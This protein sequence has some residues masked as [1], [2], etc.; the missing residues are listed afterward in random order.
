MVFGFANSFIDLGGE[1][2]LFKRYLKH[3]PFNPVRLS[4]LL[5]SSVYKLVFTYIFLFCVLINLLRSRR[6]KLLAALL[7]VDVLP[8]I[9]FALFVFEA[10]DM[11]RYVAALPLIFLA[12]GYAICSD[13]S[14]R[15]TKFVIVG[16]ILVSAVTNVRAMALPTLAQR[17]Q[18]VERRISPLLPLLKPGSRVVTSHLLDEVNNFTRDFLFNPI[19]RSGTLRYYA[20]VTLNTSQ[21]DHWQ[22]DFAKT[23][24]DVWNDNG[25]VWVSKRL[26]SQTPKAEWNWVEGDDSRVSWKDL[27]NFFLQF[28]F[29]KETIEEDGFLLLSRSQ[30]NQWIV[31][32]LAQNSKQ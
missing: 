16:F 1:G 19:N 21:V 12:I 22:Q 14:L 31:N 13:E 17:E 20:V 26:L 24:L 10:G 3:D 28:D 7:L 18:R 25:D 4:D 27:N 8:T 11:S 9:I 30:R 32:Q 29:E 5:W 2:G 23:V 15:W 6:G